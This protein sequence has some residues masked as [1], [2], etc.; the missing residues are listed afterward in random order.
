MGKKSLQQ[1]V[2]AI[3]MEIKESQPFPDTIHNN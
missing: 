2:L 1:I 3:H